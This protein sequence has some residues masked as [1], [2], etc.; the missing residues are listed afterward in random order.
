M[1]R[2]VGNVTRSQVEDEIIKPFLMSGASAG[3]GILDRPLICELPK[4]EMHLHLD[5]SMRIATIKELADERGIAL[6]SNDIDELTR[7]LIVL[8]KARSVGDYLTKFA[9]PLAVLQDAEA[10]E[11]AA[12]ELVEDLEKENVFY[13]EIRYAPMLHI[14][15]GLRMEEAIEAVLEGIR[16]GQEKTGVRA[17]VIAC[18]MRHLSPDQNLAMTQVAVRY[19]DY[20]LVGLDLA[21]DEANYRRDILPWE[22]FKLAREK[23]LGI[24]V[25]AGEAA[26]ADSIRAALEMGATRIGH[27]LRL[28]DDPALVEE[29]SRRG[30]VLEICPTSNVQ[31]Q[32]VSGLT[33][34]PVAAYLKSDLAVTVNTDNRTISHTTMTDEYELLANSFCWG[35]N[36][37][38]ATTLSAFQGAFLPESEKRD[39]LFQWSKRWLE[40]YDQRQNGR[41]VLQDFSSVEGI[42]EAC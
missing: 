40:C 35:I 13:A 17:G 41:D 5:G 38:H 18:C 30:V 20:G 39:L 33:T 6:P 32:S 9:Y 42:E 11:R 28:G 1:G 7:E 14:N 31:T 10:L 12:Y 34:H 16:R 25:H 3:S 29:V 27:A 36:E 23:G 15:K 2:G 24:T 8:D 4:A 22:A 26:G 21:G 37:M 19:H